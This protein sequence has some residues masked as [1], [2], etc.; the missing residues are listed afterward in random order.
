[1]KDQVAPADQS[2]PAPVADDKLFRQYQEKAHLLGIIWLLTTL[3]VSSNIALNIWLARRENPRLITDVSAYAL[4]IFCG[5]CFFMGIAAFLRKVVAYYFI[6]ILSLIFLFISCLTFSF[7]SIM[8]FA[9]CLTL[10][11]LTL[12]VLTLYDLSKAAQRTPA[13]PS[14]PAVPPALD[15][16]LRMV[17]KPAPVQTTGEE[18]EG[19]A[20]SSLAQAEPKPALEKPTP[21]PSIS[22]EESP[23]GLP[24][25]DEPVQ[26]V[27]KP[28]PGQVLAEEEVW[29]AQDEPVGMFDKPVP[30]QTTGAEAESSV[31]PTA[32]PTYIRFLCPE[33]GTRFKAKPEAVGKRTKCS[34]CAAVMIVPMPLRA[35]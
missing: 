3:F 27:D 10:I 21:A 28:V 24:I 7:F 11:V 17:Q 14:T 15:K 1:M 31:T 12:Q 23:A 32:A 20:A 5:I 4:E 16:P 18:K 35:R 2:F 25:P 29:L 19:I 13:R 9:L 8:G 30:V 26:M 6:F 34:Q 22:L 33:C